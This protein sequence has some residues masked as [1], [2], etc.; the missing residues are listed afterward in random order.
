MIELAMI[1]SWPIVLFVTVMYI[2]KRQAIQERIKILEAYSRMADNIYV[3]SLSKD[4]TTVFKR[5]QEERRLLVESCNGTKVEVHELYYRDGSRVNASNES[6]D[7]FLSYCE[8]FER[9][10]REK[11]NRWLNSQGRSWYLKNVKHQDGVSEPQAKT[12]VA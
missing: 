8:Q 1:Y 6:W 5:A 4:D 12:A 7:E 10:D 9:N 3:R 11:R 2:K